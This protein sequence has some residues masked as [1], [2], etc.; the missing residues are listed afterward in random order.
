MN[1]ILYAVPFF[2]V[3]IAAELIADRW[4]GMSNYRLADAVNSISTGVLSTTTGLLTKGVGLVTYG[5]A[6]EHLALVRLSADSVWVWVFAFVFYDFCYYWLHR[7]GHERNILWAAHSVHHQSEDY[8]LSTALRQTST[9]FLLSWIFYLPMA[10]LGVPLLVFVSVAALNLL[11]QF[12]VHTKHIPKLGWFEWCFV[13]PSNHRAHHAQNALY[14]DRNYGGVFIIWDRLFG[15]FQEEDDNEPVIFGV[16]TPLASWNPLWANLQFYAQ[17]WDDARRAERT[18][19]KLRIWFMRTGWRPAD[20]AAKYPMNKPDLS[21]FR[22][23]EVPLDSRQQWYVGLQ[24]GVY[25]ALGSY[26]MNLEHSL[27][28]GAL[29]LGWG[30]VAFGLFVLG[31]ALENRPWAAKLEVLRLASNL[32]LVWL[33]PLVGLWPASPGIWVGLL[34]YSLLSGIGLYCCRQRLTRLAS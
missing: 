23:F 9:G 24:F 12:W 20:V 11:Y 26:L 29:L 28:T 34:S 27:P 16:T 13:T 6:L 14:M 18:W 4:R 1:F 32:P 19:D 5:F 33:A 31:V 3:L 8:N 15:S 30:A 21:Q 7:M 22:K 10:V 25:V 2:F 17:L